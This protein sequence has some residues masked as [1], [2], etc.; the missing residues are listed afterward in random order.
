MSMSHR[1]EPSIHLSNALNRMK[2][3][4]DILDHAHAAEDIGAMLDLAIVRLEEFLNSKNGTLTHVQAMIA[5]IEHDMVLPLSTSGELR[6][7]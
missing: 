5:R 6:T 4:L 3:A 7:E 1:G 2:S